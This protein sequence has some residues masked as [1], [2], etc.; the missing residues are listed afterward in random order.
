MTCIVGI[1]HSGSVFDLAQF[2]ARLP[3]TE[4][5][6]RPYQLAALE[7]LANRENDTPL[8]GLV[9]GRPFPHRPSVIPNIHRRN[10]CTNTV[11][12]ETKPSPWGIEFMCAKLEEMVVSTRQARL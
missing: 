7:S 8:P 9:R 2:A 10:V 5:K 3:E 12:L 11:A 6:L 4:M 1:V